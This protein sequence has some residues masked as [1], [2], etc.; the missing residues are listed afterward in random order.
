MSLSL[1]TILASTAAALTVSSGEITTADHRIFIAVVALLPALFTAINR[2][3]HFEN[4]AQWAW[5]RA[6]LYEGVLRA[7]EYEN[8]EIPSASKRVTEIESDL[9]NEWLLYDEGGRSSKNPRKP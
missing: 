7:L 9:A 2:G 8:F 4:R 6:R 1:V 3:M 5:K